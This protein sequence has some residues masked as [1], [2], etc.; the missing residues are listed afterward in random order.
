MLHYYRIDITEGT[1]AAKIN[2]NKEF[3]I[4]YYWFFNNGFK[5]Q[6]SVWNGDHDLTIFCLNTSDIVIITVKN[7]DFRRIIQDIKKSEVINLLKNYG[8]WLYA[9]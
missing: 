1:D 9:I 6:D 2:S 3:I 4:L 5:F 8:K 7:V